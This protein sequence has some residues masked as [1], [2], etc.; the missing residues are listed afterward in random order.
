ML[1]RDIFFQLSVRNVRIHF[2]RSLLA[3]VGIVIGVIAIASMGMMGANLQLLLKDE[4]SSNADTIIVEPRGSDDSYVSD[5][6]VNRIKLVAGQNIVVP[7]YSRMDRI[8]Y[9]SA[10]GMAYIHGIDPVKTKEFLPLV[11]GD[12]PK[13]D[14]NVLIGAGLVTEADIRVGSMIKIGDSESG[15]QRMVRVSGIIEKRGYSFDLFTDYS[16]VA[17]ERFYEN[18]YSKNGNYDQVNII[19][20]NTDEIPE[21]VTN[22]ERLLNKNKQS[23]DR[24]Y[25]ITD[26]GSQLKDIQDNIG[27]VSSFVMAMG[28]ITLLVAA[29]SI[30][31]VMMMSVTERIRE[32]GILRSIGTEKIEIRKM[33]LYEAT[34]IGLSGSV[35][36]AVLSVIFGYIV[37]ALVVRET[38]Y[39]LSFDS[40]MYVPAGII[41]GLATCI[42]SGIYPAWRA[43]NLD[44]VE[45]LAS[46]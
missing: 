10:V 22:L 3:A 23:H 33:F 16:V 42:L 30:F 12:Y 39:F 25:R 2:L 35:I 14:S 37:V 5:M 20:A 8:G 27:M 32:I 36:G 46:E 1:M 29:I 19:A 34:L 26:S 4:L 7:V 15:N 44:P 9:G 40:L 21:I 24:D 31:N 13:S 38:D 43:S 41:I 6:T 45:A 28:A 17:T 11:D 18:F